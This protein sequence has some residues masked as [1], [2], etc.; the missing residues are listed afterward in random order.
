MIEGVKA[1]NDHNDNEKKIKGVI[2]Y[3]SMTSREHNIK[4]SKN[5]KL[6]LGV[7]IEINSIIDLINNHMVN[8]T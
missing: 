2:I 1:Y 4:Q 8:Q 6:V 7:E 3:T 5:E